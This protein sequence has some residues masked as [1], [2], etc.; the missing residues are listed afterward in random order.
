MRLT[1]SARSHWRPYVSGRRDVLFAG[2]AIAIAVAT[3][4]LVWFL[5][6]VGG[7]SNDRSVSLALNALYA[8]VPFVPVERELFDYDLAEV[9]LVAGLIAAWNAGRIGAFERDAVRRRVLL[10]VATF[11]PTYVVSRAIQHFG[12]APRP[13]QVLPL[14]PLVSADLWKMLKFQY[15]G[16]GS[17]PS[18]HAALAAI[19]TV[20]AF[21]LGRKPGW[22]FA[23]FG[24]FASLD[25][26]ATGFHWP[27]DIAGGV[28]VGTVVACLVLAA[29][30]RLTPALDRVLALFRTNP[31]GAN[32]TAVLFLSEMGNGFSRLAAVLRDLGFLRRLFH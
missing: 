1:G 10:T 6:S 3:V 13:I 20:M 21:S 15:H 30:T 29:E 27:S 31:V 2:A 32:V 16:G 17:F 4:A 7:V 14:H 8:R 11:V 24:L 25:R 22:F 18:A 19:A 5:D 28:I 26:V 12:H 9:V 23:V